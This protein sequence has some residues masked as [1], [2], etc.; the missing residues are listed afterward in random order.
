MIPPQDFV[1]NLLNF[2]TKA[3]FPDGII[4]IPS[5]A[6]RPHLTLPGQLANY[7][8]PTGQWSPSRAGRKV[9]PIQSAIAS[10]RRSSICF[11]TGESRTK[12][13]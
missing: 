11:S 1:P 9:L 6:S 4:D 7:R 13:N 10:L 5:A 2:L 12:F 8:Q 3:R